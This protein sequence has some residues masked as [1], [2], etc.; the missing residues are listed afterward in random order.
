M[1]FS[2]DVTG[3]MSTAAS[4]FNSLFP[5]FGVIAGISIGIGLVT[6]IIVEIRKAF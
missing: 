1:S 4:M 5:I 3:M 2:I 6:L